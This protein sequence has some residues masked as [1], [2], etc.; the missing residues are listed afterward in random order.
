MN[1]RQ[2]GMSSSRSVTIAAIGE[3][4]ERVSVT[5]AKSGWPFSASITA[6]DPVVPADPQVV[7]LGDVVGEH[8][9][10]ALADPGQHGEQHPALQRLRLVHDHEGVVQAAPADVGQRQHLEHAR[11]R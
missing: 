2:S 10:R 6:V 8:H 1:G 11:A 4:S 7:P 9:P 5:C 3:R